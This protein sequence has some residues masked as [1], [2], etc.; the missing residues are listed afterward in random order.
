MDQMYSAPI[1]F[2]KRLYRQVIGSKPPM[3]AS[4]PLMQHHHKGTGSAHSS[5][6][7]SS[8]RGLCVLCTST[9]IGKK[10]FYPFSLARSFIQRP[11][12]AFVWM[13][14]PAGAWTFTTSVEIQ[15]FAFAFIPMQDDYVIRV[16]ITATWMDPHLPSE[17]RN[18]VPV[19][20]LEA[21]IWDA[22]CGVPRGCICQTPP[23][24][25]SSRMWHIEQE[26]RRNKCIPLRTGSYKRTCM[27]C[28]KW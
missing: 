15:L 24:C 19:S 7:P 27:M 23:T 4:K 16:I 28:V 6:E 12:V 14:K 11:A 9:I 1:Y 17:L 2:V 13:G 21:E 10:F 8:S 25:L 26:A 3:Q 20:P 5:S 18:P 22:S